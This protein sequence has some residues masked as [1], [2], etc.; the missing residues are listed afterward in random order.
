LEVVHVSRLFYRLNC[1]ARSRYSTF[2]KTSHVLQVAHTHL[3]YSAKIRRFYELVS[4]CNTFLQ[5]ILQLCRYSRFLLIL[6]ELTVSLL[7]LK[8]VPGRSR[9]F[10]LL[11]ILGSLLFFLVKGRLIG[12]VDCVVEHDNFLL[13]VRFGLH[14]ALVVFIDFL[15]RGLLAMTQGFQSLSAF[16]QSR[17]YYFLLVLF[18]HEHVQGLGLFVLFKERLKFLL[19]L[20][21][22]IFF[23]LDT[24]DMLSY[25]LAVLFSPLSLKTSP[26]FRLQRFL[27]SPFLFNRPFLFLHFFLKLIEFFIDLFDS[28]FPLLGHFILLRHFII[29]ILN[30]KLHL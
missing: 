10:K 9:F 2:L 13:S 8:E 14:V 27:F 25:L 15:Q 11:H 18:L 3:V 28:L 21:P 29:K 23:L 12:N 26:D 6:Y 22:L 24:L 4:L 30:T 16:F 17:Q 7:L 19:V 20:L 1:H 5:R